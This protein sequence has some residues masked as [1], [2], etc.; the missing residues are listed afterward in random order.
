MTGI[1]AALPSFDCT[2]VSSSRSEVRFV[3]VAHP[4]HS[5][6]FCHR[7]YSYG[8]NIPHLCLNDSPVSAYT[9]P[10]V[11]YFND[12]FISEGKYT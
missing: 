12:Q 9:L 1:I 5:R 8:C 6:I 4:S 10:S 3:D 11:G 7:W 2:V